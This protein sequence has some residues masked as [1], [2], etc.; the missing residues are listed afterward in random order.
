MVRSTRPVIL[1][2][3]FMGSER[4][5]STCY[6]FFNESSIPF[7]SKSNGYKNTKM[8]KE[9]GTFFSGKWGKDS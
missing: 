6:I 7:Y 1:I 8:M 4:L 9:T 2:I 5:P 3:Y